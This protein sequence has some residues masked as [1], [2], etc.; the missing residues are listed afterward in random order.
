MSGRGLACQSA[1]RACHRA[2]DWQSV[3]WNALEKLRDVFFGRAATETIGP[4]WTD[5][6]QLASYDFTLGRRI[7][8][9]WAAVLEPLCAD[10]WTPPARQLVDWGCG[11]G[12]GARSLLAYAP[13]DSFD[14]VVL[15]DHSPAATTFASD[16]IRARFPT[17]TVRVA[18]PATSVA[19]GAFVLVVS[20]VLNE[21]DADGREALLALARRAATILW[22]EP[23]TPADSR[24]LIAMRENLRGEF[25]CLAPCTHSDTCG[26]LA[27]E[28]APHWCHHFARPPTEAFTESGW[29]EFG[30]RLGIDLR[31]LPYSYLVLD[32]RGPSRAPDLVRVIGEPRTSAG[33]MRIFR[34]RAEGVSEVELQK[35]ADPALWRTLEKGKHTG[36]FVWRESG[37]RIAE[38]MPAR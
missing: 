31:S 33:L 9:K 36:V 29:A 23:G 22:V 11:T 30:R 38:G 14:E 4:Y 2:V 5:A 17:M 28:N 16:A 12:I 27:T 21:L 19:D 13:P 3:D 24:A 15:W 10:G 1:A 35:R 8:W 25:H 32:R 37:G 18:D 20:H 34:C 26:L 6:A 7:A